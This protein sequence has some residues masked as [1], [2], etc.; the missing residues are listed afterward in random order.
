[1][2]EL[3][4]IQGAATLYA[5]RTSPHFLPSHQPLV[6]CST[7]SEPTRHVGYKACV[8]MVWWDDSLPVGVSTSAGGAWQ[9]SLDDCVDSNRHI[10]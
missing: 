4:L 5:C 3:K 9:A 7:I 1:M 2:Q 8:V 10:K 6:T